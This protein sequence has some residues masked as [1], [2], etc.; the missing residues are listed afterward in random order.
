FNEDFGDLTA[1][2]TQGYVIDESPT[3]TIDLEDAL[4][5]APMKEESTPYP[6]AN[7]LDKVVDLVTVVDDEVNSKHKIAEFFE[8]DERQGDYYANAACYLGLLERNDH[9]FELT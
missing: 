8:F 1:R 4:Q 7:D 3:V 9:R 2:R 5:R 6:Q